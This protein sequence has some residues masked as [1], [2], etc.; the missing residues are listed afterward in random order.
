[1]YIGPIHVGSHQVCPQLVQVIQNRSKIGSKRIDGKS[2]T[3][4]RISYSVETTHEC[5]EQRKY[6]VH[7]NSTLATTLTLLDGHDSLCRISAHCKLWLSEFSDPLHPE[8][9]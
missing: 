1:M 4:R 2:R 8:G 5:V 3:F 7:F 6:T 9:E